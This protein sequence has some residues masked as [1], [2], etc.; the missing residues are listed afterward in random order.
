[1]LQLSVAPSLL[2]HLPLLRPL[3]LLVRLPLVAHGSVETHG[4]DD[5]KGVEVNHDHFLTIQILLAS[6]AGVRD[7]DRSVLGGEA[8]AAV[9]PPGRDVHLEVSCG[10]RRY[11]RHESLGG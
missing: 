4:G 5:L 3:G 1:M 9:V 10:Y 11:R 2:L 6:V 7:Q 8:G